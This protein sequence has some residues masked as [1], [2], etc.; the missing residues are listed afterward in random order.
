MT[1]EHCCRDEGNRPTIVTADGGQRA[2]EILTAL[3]D[4]QRRY[5]LYYLR[6]EE[7][8]S[9]ADVAER[10]AVWEYDAPA[11][12]IPETAIEEYRTVLYHEHLPMLREA[13]LVEYDERSEQ[14]VF[15]D[16]PDLAEL[17]LEHCR[18]S[19]LPD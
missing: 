16:C 11:D 6:D 2:D 3:A 9:V 15:R 14:L 7:R 13:Q 17:C 12:E 5:V 4:I 8:A 1:D 10:L 18:E 19:D